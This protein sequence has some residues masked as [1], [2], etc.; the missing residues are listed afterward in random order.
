M[1]RAD[2]IAAIEKIV[3]NLETA[4]AEIEESAKMIYGDL[5]TAQWPYQV[6][7]LQQTMINTAGELRRLLAQMR[8]KS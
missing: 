4:P 8:G 3:V 6:G 2:I 5:R 7:S 1:K